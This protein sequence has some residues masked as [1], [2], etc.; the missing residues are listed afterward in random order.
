MKI[1]FLVTSI[2]FSSGKRIKNKVIRQVLFS[3]LNLSFWPWAVGHSLT[4]I[5][6]YGGLPIKVP[7][8]QIR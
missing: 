1:I 4:P 3:L 6:I 8:E 5:K 7:L 2:I